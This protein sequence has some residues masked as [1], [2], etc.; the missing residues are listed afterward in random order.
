MEIKSP[1]TNQCIYSQ[2]AHHEKMDMPMP[3]ICIAAFTVR[4][5]YVKNTDMSR[6][7]DNHN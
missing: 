1:M 5:M 6:L 3:V 4:N 2:D 7:G